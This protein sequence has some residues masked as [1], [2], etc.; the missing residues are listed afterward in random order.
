[1]RPRPAGGRRH[2]EAP[3]KDADAATRLNSGAEVT[4]A[5]PWK[6]VEFDR[7]VEIL[8]PSISFDFLK[9]P[10]VYLLIGVMHPLLSLI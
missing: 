5:P 4:L 7:W 2:F 6:A 3:G 8:M 9:L 1:M 10:D